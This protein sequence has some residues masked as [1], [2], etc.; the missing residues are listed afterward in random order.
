M[1]EEILKYI[2]Y[3]K[4]DD[5][6]EI[7]KFIEANKFKNFYKFIHLSDKDLNYNSN[8]IY[9]YNRISFKKLDTNNFNF[10][11]VF[12]LL[13]YDK[14]EYLLE[15]DFKYYHYFDEICN[16]KGF[17]KNLSDEYI[18]ILSKFRL[19]NYSYKNI[20]CDLSL[21]KEFIYLYNKGYDFTT[22]HK[23]VILIFN[24]AIK[25]TTDFELRKK[26]LQ[27]I[28]NDDLNYI[29]ICSMMQNDII[30]Q[31]HGY[32]IETVI[33]F[34]KFYINKGFK[35]SNR[36]FEDCLENKDEKY[37]KILMRIGINLSE[38]TIGKRS[39]EYY[40]IELHMLEILSVDDNFDKFIKNNILSLRHYT[41]NEAFMYMISYLK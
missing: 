17:N 3:I 2:E 7:F 40:R 5:K 14:I 26:L 8:L 23:N 15:I 34:Y 4:N 22:I 12:I 30:H 24:C 35:I 37:I 1:R 19:E 31:S 6:D 32:D 9:T 20:Q 36:F 38:I 29:S 13:V 18:E 27:Y 21:E 11:I 28:T 41:T 10:F 16:V 25:Y 33:D 39:K